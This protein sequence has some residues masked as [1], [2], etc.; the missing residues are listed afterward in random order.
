MHHTYSRYGSTID[1]VDRG[2]NITTKIFQQL[3][4][5]AKLT[6]YVLQYINWPKRASWMVVMYYIYHSSRT[7]DFWK[8]KDVALHWWEQ[9]ENRFKRT[10][11]LREEYNNSMEDYL[12]LDQLMY[13]V[14]VQSVDEHNVEHY[15][16]CSA[17]LRPK[18]TTTRIRIAFY[19]SEKSSSG[20]S[21][22]DNLLCWAKLQQELTIA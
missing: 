18:S 2:P 8:S 11:K 20:L 1:W 4:K 10:P 9:L 19:A 14:K 13:Q 3:K 12:I 6:W 16:P 5:T 17:V 15:I 7:Q 21:L 22:N